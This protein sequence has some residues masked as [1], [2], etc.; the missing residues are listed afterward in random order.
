LTL[1]GALGHVERLESTRGRGDPVWQL[2]V[3]GV[4]GDGDSE[5]VWLVPERLR[6]PPRLVDRLGLAHLTRA[7]VQMHRVQVNDAAGVRLVESDHD[8]ACDP[9]RFARAVNERCP[10]APD[11]QTESQKKTLSSPAESTL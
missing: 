7:L 11:Y 1:E 2:A 10:H 9:G 4:G 8:R 6:V 3:G 5:S